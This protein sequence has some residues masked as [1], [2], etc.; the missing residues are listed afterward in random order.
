MLQFIRDRAQGWI[1]LAIVG[2]LILGLGSFAWDS[3]FGPDPEVPVASVDGEKI[4][5]NEFQREYQRQKARLQA[6]AGGVDFSRLVPDETQFKLNIL[7]QLV[8]EKLILQSAVDSGFHVSDQLLSQQIR[9]FEAFQ[10][11]GQFDSALYQQWLGQNFYSP[12]AFEDM[13]RSNVMVQQYRYGI[14]ATAWSSEQERNVILQ[15]Q[16]QQRDIGYIQVNAADYADMVSVA[17]EAIKGYYDNNSNRFATPE[18]VSVEYLELSIDGLS[19]DIDVNEDALKELYE[20]RL[21]EFG[22]PEQRHTRHILLETI[23]D[24]SAEGLASVRKKAEDLVAKIRAGDSFETLASDHSDD[25]GSSRNGGDLGFLARDSMLDPAFADAAFAL[26][27]DE[28]SDPVKTA[29]GFHI[30][31]LEDIK[32]GDVKSFAEVHDQLAENYRQQ[33]AEEVFFEQGEILANM[34]F[35]NPDSL[36]PAAEELG[37]TVKSTPL[38]TGDMGPGI[39]TEA[40]VRLLAFSDDV[41]RQ[42]NNSEPLELDGGKLIVLRIKEHQESAIRAYDEVKGEITT[43]LRRE[44]AEERAA[45]EAKVILQQLLDGADAEVLAKEKELQWQRPGKLERKDIDLDVDILIEAFRLGHP[46]EGKANYGSLKLI[47]GDY[48]VVALF[49]VEDGDTA[50]VEEEQRQAIKSNRER[51]YGGSELL[52]AISD[53]HKDAEVRKYLDNL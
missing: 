34:S 11:E 41:L 33:R 43:Y 13:L 14:V 6:M 39:A 5:S 29:Y 3:Y 22:V 49:A 35:E 26:K 27:K 12:G 36:E 15:K 7:N 47:S 32:A 46:E 17:D 37:L 25:I 40:K 50:A 51:F 23:A 42:D 18:K 4:T 30:I 53:L 8:D 1:A 44:Q 2:M 19:K 31:K 48:A 24:A 21:S 10:S 16:E 20:E 45:I 52:G 38:F 9:S 28:V